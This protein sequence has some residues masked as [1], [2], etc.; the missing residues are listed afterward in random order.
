MEFKGNTD[1]PV[2]C[3]T[4]S[5]QCEHGVVR[6]PTGPGF[7]VTLDPK[8]VEGTGASVGCDIFDIMAGRTMLPPR[9]E[10]RR[11]ESP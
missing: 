3:A 1:L 10:T 2:A 9:R 6:C 4:S 11:R 5:L 7:G 8:F